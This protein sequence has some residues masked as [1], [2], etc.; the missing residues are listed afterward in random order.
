MLEVFCRFFRSN[1]TTKSRDDEM[2]SNFRYNVR[3]SIEETKL[4]QIIFEIA[5]GSI[6]YMLLKLRT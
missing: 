3:I 4:E 2:D 1:C 6:F 5:V